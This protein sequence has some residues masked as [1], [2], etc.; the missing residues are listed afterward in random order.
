M[1]AQPVLTAEEWFKRMRHAPPPSEDD[2]SVL[3]DG[4]RL[5]SQEK[6]MAWLAQIEEKRNADRA[7][8][9]ADAES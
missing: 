6:V 8:A 1:P 7:A 4:T 2:V 5:D 9:C 3:W